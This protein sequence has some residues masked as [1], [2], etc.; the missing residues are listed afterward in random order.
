MLTTA[1]H[2]HVCAHKPTNTANNPNLNDQFSVLSAAINAFRWNLNTSFN[3]TRRGASKSGMMFWQTAPPAGFSG[4][5]LC[6]CDGID[7]VRSNGPE[8][9]NAAWHQHLTSVQLSGKVL[10]F[11]I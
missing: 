2:E 6:D 7:E 9:K 5:R 4:Y 10:Q 1:S 3:V 8:S 11:Y